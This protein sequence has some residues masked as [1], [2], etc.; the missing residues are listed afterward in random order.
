MKIAIF[1]YTRQGAKLSCRLEQS[2]TECE[3]RKYAVKK[4]CE[5]GFLPIEKPSESFYGEK[6]AE[7]DVLIFVG[8]CQIAVREIAPHI[9]NKKTDPAVLCIDVS[10]RFVIPIL[11][12]HIGGANKLANIIAEI[13]GSTAVITTATDVNQR[14]AADCWA[15][16][17]GYIIGD[18]N[19]AKAVSAEILE[20]NVP[21]LSE[22]PITSE[23][24]SGIFSSISGACGIYIG[25]KALSPFETTLNLIPRVLNVGIGC[26]KGISVEQIEFALNCVFI[27]NK[28]DKRAIKSFNSIDI[29]SH[30]TGLSKL[31]QK[32]KVPIFFYGADELNRVSGDF[33]SS[34]FVKEI[35]GVDNVCE[36]AAMLNS[37]LLIV[38]KTPVD[39]VTIAVAIE[40]TEVCFE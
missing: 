18:M 37:D 19:A 1:T 12:G 27:K 30:E 16:E 39:G 4:F 21:L 17:N 25:I 40:N 2:L 36:R 24:P 29:K 6:F 15:E 26:R 7:F 28:I 9:K 10:A 38:P 5:S 33:D 3:I 31:S 34:E 14:F 32:Y 11:S 35:T 20:H 22:F 8:A 23:L 13:L